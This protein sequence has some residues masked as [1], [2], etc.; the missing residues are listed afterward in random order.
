M[1]HIP[2]P[3]V[4]QQTESHCGPAVL[5]QLLAH[6]GVQLTQDSIVEAAGIS[7]SIEVDGTRPKELAQS[8]AK[9][10]PE[11]QFWFKNQATK[12][13]LFRL[14]HEFN[15]PVGINWQGLFYNTPEEEAEE[16]DPDRNRGHYSVVVDIN[17]EADTITIADTYEEF[18]HSPR[19]FSLSWFESRWWDKVT[20][21]NPDTEEIETTATNHF[22][23]VVAPK[24]VTFPRELDMELPDQLGIITKTSPAI[25]PL[26][27]I[28]HLPGQ[29]AFIRRFVP[30]SEDDFLAMK[31]I[32]D[33]APVKEWMDNVG[34]LSF[35]AFQEWASDNSDDA[36]LFAVHNAL[37]TS[38]RGA[39]SV[40]GFIYLYSGDEEK[41]KV[42]KMEQQGVFDANKDRWAMEVSF[43]RRTV[44]PNQAQVPGLVSSALRQACIWAHM[45]LTNK[46]PVP[47]EIFA[48]ID[49][50]NHPAWRT[51]EAAGFSKRGM[52]KYDIDSPKD[53]EL[54]ILDWHELSGKLRLSVG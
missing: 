13:E 25:L 5:K 15:W 16:E 30:E 14:I 20:D 31:A 37:A 45:F 12:Q 33:E 34:D 52:M 6:V 22:M 9:L 2:L 35:T 8:V 7:G 42:A 3:T 51:L 40:L 23:F 39:D 44:G 19:T 53:D 49:P 17:L 32:M 43:A 50:R 26:N 29:R 24:E 47:V 27:T 38:T 18:A 46:R 28:F 41:A 1:T 21:S 36:F 10:A 54:F 11:L 4:V 48:F